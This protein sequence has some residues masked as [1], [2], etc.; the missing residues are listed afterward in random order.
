[1]QGSVHTVG[2]ERMQANI[3]IPFLVVLFV[4]ALGTVLAAAGLWSD[5]APQ[6]RQGSLPLA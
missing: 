6:T 4:V 1:V 2:T 3:N 5:S